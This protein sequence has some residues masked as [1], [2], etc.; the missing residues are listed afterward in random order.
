MGMTAEQKAD[1]LKSGGR[2]C[3]YCKSQNLDGEVTRYDH[4]DPEQDVTCLDCGKSWTDILGPIDVSDGDELDYPLEPLNL[5]IVMSLCALDVGFDLKQ[6]PEIGIDASEIEDGDRI[7][8]DHSNG[9]REVLLWDS[10]VSPL[11]LRAQ[12]YRNRFIVE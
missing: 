7:V 8:Y 2:H 10:E 6:H 12:G 5:S 3:P 4:D 1:Y 9:K 11:F